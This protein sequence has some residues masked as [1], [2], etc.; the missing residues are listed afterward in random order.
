MSW[1]LVKACGGNL[2]THTQRRNSEIS[3]QN[4]VPHFAWSITGYQFFLPQV[5]FRL[6][7]QLQSAS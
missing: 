4:K 5:P 6:G 7:V 3:S 2:Q 1:Q